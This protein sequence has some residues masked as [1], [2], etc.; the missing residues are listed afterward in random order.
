[1]EWEYGEITRDILLNNRVKRQV[2]E[3]CRMGMKRIFFIG[4]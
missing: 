2:D 4:T 1:M 3:I